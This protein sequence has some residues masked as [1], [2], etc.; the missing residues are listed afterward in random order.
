LLYCLNP[1]G[2]EPL[3]TSLISSFGS[4]SSIFKVLE[5]TYL[6][7]DG[8]VERT[9]ELEPKTKERNIK[10]K[11]YR[12]VKNFDHVHLMALAKSNFFGELTW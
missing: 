9:K 12:S 11:P 5:S 4:Q 7:E 3:G 1:Q 2:E 8:A 6:K 10:I